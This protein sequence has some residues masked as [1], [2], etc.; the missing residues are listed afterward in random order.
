VYVALILPGSVFALEAVWNFADIMNALMVI[1]NMIALLG[2]SGI[3]QKETKEFI[4]SE[5][6]PEAIVSDVPAPSQI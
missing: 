2:L 6:L 5:T 1:P 4:A 3:V